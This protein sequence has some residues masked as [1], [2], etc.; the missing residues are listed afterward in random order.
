MAFDTFVINNFKDGGYIYE[1]TDSLNLFGYTRDSIVS[2][3]GMVYLGRQPAGI[4][5]WS[6]GYN[7]GLG[8]I[9]IKPTFSLLNYSTKDTVC[10]SFG[11]INIT[12]NIAGSPVSG[13]LQFF[14]YKNNKVSS[15]N[16]YNYAS[17]YPNGGL[18]FSNATS[19]STGFCD[20]NLESGHYLNSGD[21]VYFAVYSSAQNSASFDYLVKDTS[22]Q[23]QC[24]AIGTQ[25]LV[26]PYKLH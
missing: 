13:G 17:L 15:N 22:G 1:I 10:G 4:G 12:V 7:M 3:N 20:F 21:S 8:S 16:L 6:T 14:F 26:I 9:Q 19:V 11:A 18:N 5:S 2:K 25:R 24:T 23:F